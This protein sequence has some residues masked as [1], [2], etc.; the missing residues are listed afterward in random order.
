[1]KTH[2]LNAMF[3]VVH[4]FGGTSM[5]DAGC[6]SRVLGLLDAHGAKRQV[7]VVSAMK[8]TTDTLIALAHTHGDPEP[9]IAAIRERHASAAAELLSGSDFQQRLRE[10]FVAELEHDLDLVRSL[11]KTQ[12]LLK[13]DMAAVLDFV[14]GLG[15]VFSARLLCAVAVA[16]GQKAAFIDARDVLVVAPGDLGVVVDFDASAK[17]LAACEIAF[18]SDLVVVTGFIARDAERRATT[19]G[20]NG[21]DF[22]GAIFARLF[23]ARDLQ[24]WTDV[25]GVLS[26]D[27]RLVPEAQLIE[28]VS[29]AEAFEL[30]YF[31]AKVIHPQ[32]LKP[33]IERGI[34]IT[35]RNTFNPSHPGTRIIERPLG[36]ADVHAVS[37]LS[38]VEGLALI[39]VEGAGM[40]GVPG[41]AERVFA[42]LKV[43]AISVVMIS[44]GSS[45]HS[46]CFALKDSD[47]ERALAALKH[48]F[49]RE[50]ASGQIEGVRA[51]SG[52]G[53]LAAVGDG[54]AGRPGVA[55]RLFQAL[56]RARVNVRAIAQGASERN[57]S[58]AVDS[59]DVIRALRAAHAAF[60]LAPQTLGL[61]V[62]GVGSVGQAFLRELNDHAAR[63]KSK[64]AID[65]KLLGVANSKHMLRLKGGEDLSDPKALLLQ[66]GETLDFRA[67]I[68]HG[69]APE[70]PALVVIDLTASE[71]VADQYAGW[72]EQGAHIVSA[73]KRAGSGPTERYARI[74]R[75]SERSTARFYFEATV[76]AG[77]PVIQSLDDLLKSGD[78][79]L[80]I[81]ATLSGTLAYLFAELKPGDS[82][83]ALVAQAQALRFTEPDPRDD[84]SG[85]DVA[86]KLVILARYAGI[87]CELSD[88]QV[89]SLVPESLA[90]GS[91]E[92][93]LSGLSQFDAQMNERIAAAHARGKV[94][95]YAAK[96][97]PRRQLSVGLLEL[98]PN[99]AFARARPSDNV[100]AFSTRRYRD[101]P[102]IIQGPGAGPEVTAAGVLA[103]LLRL[104]QRYA[105]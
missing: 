26:A 66:A 62:V 85:L 63:L 41:T 11:L 96:L 88:V 92:E 83:A 71:T 91:T 48:D 34:I 25:D 1:M 102:L 13:H 32:T 60:Y 7:V 46:I 50:L 65:L 51:D 23:H 101:N 81:E 79:L 16:R 30:A 49:A 89:E 98:D 15:E 20:R 14:Q 104:A 31:G 105:L 19:L 10:R 33:A 61:I 67:L 43:R 6:I 57:I 42:A 27:P 95:R 86:R 77:L 53:I 4:K 56:A 12:A 75:A 38:V 103:D 97:G 84:L 99:H 82:F 52:I 24:I 90:A 59:A 54:M 69:R 70:Y 18:E 2:S 94:L 35:I 68:E 44:Q 87:D 36:R 47:R 40:I 73:S 58:V 78:E 5:A 37:G 28:E 55:A 45:E 29:Y 22:S 100:I 64:H 80:G 17:N 39:N 3:P 93:F 8:G 76:G 74:A 9:Q 72:L 21:S